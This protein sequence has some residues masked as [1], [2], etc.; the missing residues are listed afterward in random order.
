[1]LN[2]ANI[3]RGANHLAEGETADSLANREKVRLSVDEWRTIKTAVEHCTPIPNNASKNMLLG[4]HYALRQ[5]SKQLA[6][7][8]IEIQKRRD[9][10]IAA[11]DAYHR[12]CSDASYMNNKRHRQHGS[13]YENL[14]Y[15]DRQSLSKN[16]DSSFLLVDEQGNIIPKT[17][18]A[19]LVAAQAYLHTARPNPG[20]P[21]EHMHRAAL[22]GLKMVGNKLSAKEEEAYRNKGIHKPRSPHRH[23][24]PRHRSGSRRSRT[25][26]PGRHN[27]PKHKGTRRSRTPNKAYD[28][29]D[30]EK[31]MGASCFT[32]R[33]RITPVPKGFKLPHDQ[34]KYDGSQEPQS[35]LSDYLQAVKLLGGTRETA[36]QSLQLHLTG[37]ARSWLSKLGKETIGSWEDLTKQFTSNFKLTYKRPASIEEVKACVQQRNETLRAYIQGWSII[38]NSA[39]EV[40]DERAIDAFTLGLRRGDLVEEMGRLKPKI[41]SD[42]M[43]I[44]NRFADG[45]D[46]C[47]NK[48]TRSPEDDRGNRCGGQRRR[49]RNYGNYGSHSQVAAGYKDNNYQGNNRRSSGYRSYGKEDYGSNRKF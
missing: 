35:W 28:Y 37:A 38:K 27:S 10:A 2:P 9:S 31:E 45:E 46:A 8:R 16:P 44:A 22:Q 1:V 4:Y 23:N 20:D 18:E 12:A 17:P 13:R 11:S 43:D 42:L 34:Q 25:P 39:V 32:H 29:K 30:D 21:R 24:S 14:E 19:A 36:T 41:V 48:R 33:V 49:S 15:S 3:N 7:E 26:S 40:S 5:Q 6:K 47:N